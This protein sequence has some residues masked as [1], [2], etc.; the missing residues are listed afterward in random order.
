MNKQ[1][2]IDTLFSKPWKGPDYTTGFTIDQFIDYLTE[3]TASI[4]AQ[5]AAIRI[6]RSYGISGTIDVGYIANIIQEEIDK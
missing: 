2:K 6:V 4:P 3:C 5:K 1:E